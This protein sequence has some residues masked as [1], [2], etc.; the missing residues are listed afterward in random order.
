MF[1]NGRKRHP[2]FITHDSYRFLADALE[3]GLDCKMGDVVMILNVPI[4]IEEMFKQRNQCCKQCRYVKFKG[5]MTK[6][7]VQKLTHRKNYALDLPKNVTVN[8]K[9]CGLLLWP[10]DL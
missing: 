9:G 1:Y 6:W 10:H 5:T 2:P 7:P 4:Q 3:N 8:I